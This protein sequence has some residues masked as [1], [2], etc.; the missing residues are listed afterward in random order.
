MADELKYIAFRRSRLYEPELAS[1]VGPRM[2]GKLPLKLVDTFTGQS[3]PGAA[4]FM[5]AA[6]ADVAG[7][8]PRAIKHMA[9]PPG[10]RDA[11]TTKFVHVDFFE[12][13]LPWRYTPEAALPSPE[14]GGAANRVVRPWLVL[15]V[16]MAAQM[17]VK[18]NIVAVKDKAV[19][20]G[21]NLDHSY[22]WAHVQEGRYN[23]EPVPVSISR[24]LSPVALL[25]QREYIAVLVPTFNDNGERMWQPD[26]TAN[27]GRRGVLSAFH[28]WRF[29]TGE[30][31]DFE[32]LAAAL[33]IPP[34]G[35]VGKAR[36]HYRREV[37]GIDETLEVRGAITSLQ[38]PQEPPEL[39]INTIRTDV[40]TLNDEIERAIGLPHYGRPW[41]PDPDSIETGWPDDLNDDP[42]HR[43]VAGLGV[44]MGIEGQEAL[45][46]AAVAQA[47]ALRDAGRHIN[48]LALGL[49]AAGGLWQRRL[50]TDV[51][52]RLRVLGPLMRR[53]TDANGQLVMD[54]VAAAGPLPAGF[55]SGAA[56][57]LL[58][59]RSAATRHVTGANGGL[60]RGE[61]LVAANQP[62][63]APAPNPAGLPH[64][65]TIT[66][67]IGARR[68]EEHLLI[69]EERLAR[70]ME[71]AEDFTRQ[72]CLDYRAERDF[73][74]RSGR[75]DEIPLRRREIAEDRLG[76]ELV[77]IVG[78]LQRA[79]QRCEAP[80]VVEAAGT[81]LGDGVFPE[82][83]EWVL[84]DEGVEL[85]F[86]DLLFRKLVRCL[87]G[88]D[89][90]ELLP[91]HIEGNREQICDSLIDSFRRPPRHQ[92]AS[93]N[94]GPLGAALDK[95][96][97]PRLPRAPARLRVCSRIEGIDCTR[98]TR[99]EY[100][101]RLDF[102]TWTLLN[103][104]DKEWLL[105]GA[106]QL[107]K[108]SIT[109]L[110]TNPTFIDAF[111][112]GINSQF[113]SEMRW[114]DLA[115][116]RA[117]TPL[118]M[119]WGQVNYATGK[120]QADIE[121]LAEWSKD[122][123]KPIGSLAHQTIQ[124]ADPE[125]TSGSRLV[126]AFNSA[127][128]RRYPK[129]LVYLIKRPEKLAGETEQA[130][131]QRVDALLGQKPDLS[132]PPGDVEPA[133]RLGR[134]F[135]GPIL[136]ANITPDLTFFGF[137]ITPSTLDEYFLVL[138]EPPAELRFRS[139]TPRIKLNGATFAKSTLDDETRVAI[140]GE[141]LEQQALEQ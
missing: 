125:N 109:A 58:R 41:L 131:E 34:A 62:E 9:P 78:R 91:G 110:Q 122:T 90:E 70:V 102:P 61:A 136:A 129:T 94:L 43:G 44:W 113:M 54:R 83:L 80:M 69:E 100:P 31:G 85:T 97:D 105:P 8:K 24:I 111:M 19:L 72:V 67:E 114:R 32:T 46:D 6:A 39:V 137:D 103:R 87:L 118:R 106:S 10:S 116:D 126:I 81:A 135:F 18:G 95:A 66:E 76:R 53:M 22:Q 71:K 89:C 16:G 48:H 59:D 123:D 11:E 112:V 2:A 104:Y 86:F 84:E 108:D 141:Y 52:E 98:L 63:P 30:E 38:T 35:D 75:E 88:T 33:H 73:L 51:N 36:L 21:H 50:P 28:A 3:E 4:P 17:E 68:I 138:A 132:M 99:P 47:G 64:L 139:D 140:S 92:P 57:R 107:A 115:V 29:W 133:W 82:Q 56:Q 74:L 77:E 23:E 25:P 26:G 55:F 120:R 1:K 37:A 27:F 14:G 12:P 15:L 49:L 130:Y 13:D 7:L 79:F 40:D 93:V 128:F 96:L 124:P 127:L 5:L 45:M 60:N 121:P 117:I 42:R 119:F 65:A 20:A 134:R 101:I